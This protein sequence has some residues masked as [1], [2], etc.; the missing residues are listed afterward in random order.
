MMMTSQRLIKNMIAHEPIDRVG[1]DDYFWPETLDAWVEQG[2]PTQVVVN[3]GKEKLEPMDPNL[4][5]HFDLRMC[6]GFFDTEPI[7]GF[8]EILDETEDWVVKQNGAGAVLK[9]WKHK[10][11]TP[12][13]INF[14]MVDRQIWER[15]YRPHLLE[16][17]R[18]RFS[19]KGWG[20]Q[21]LEGDLVELS[22]ARSRHQWAWYGTDFFWEVM[23]SSLGDLTMYENLILDPGWINDFNAVYS[24]FFKRHFKFLFEENGLP[25]G[26][27]VFDDLAYKDR[28]FASTK[29][30]ESLFLPYYADFVQFCSSYN[31]PVF[32]HSDGKIDEALPL[33]IEAGFVA[34]NPIEAKAGCDIFEYADKYSD[35]LIFHGGLDARVLET[36]DRKAIEREVVFLIEGMKSRNARYIF[37]SDH[38]VSPRVT[39]DSYRHALEVY[40]RHMMY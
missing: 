18:R 19:G 30:L 14:H 9:W 13:H 20:S 29:I 11:G 28:L 26:I 3:K 32:F 25:D 10:M 33:I 31:L 21:G 27:R 40:Y 17:D 37:G 16:V 5:F 6:G 8:E 1:I 34:L 7:V 24:G 4:H 39:Y 23:R 36:N 38:S 15:E 22:N 35:D 2:Y 12:E